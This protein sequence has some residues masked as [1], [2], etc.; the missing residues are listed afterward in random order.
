MAFI[1]E[2]DF[3]IVSYIDTDDNVIKSDYFE[4]DDIIAPAISLLNK[5]GYKTNFCCSGHTFSRIDSILIAQGQDPNEIIP[6]D[7]LILVESS[8][9][10]KDTW[11]EEES[12]DTN[13]YPYHVICKNDICDEFYVSFDSIHEFPE[14]PKEFYFIQYPDD[15]GGCGIYEEGVENRKPLNNFDDIM[16]IVELNKKFYE[17]AEKLPSLVKENNNGK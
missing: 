17:W 8:E 12:I 3:S 2:K 11:S 13:E 4:C 5:K 16:R 1:N 7:K 14:L 10:V 15:M 9:N 6:S